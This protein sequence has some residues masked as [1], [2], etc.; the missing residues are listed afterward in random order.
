MQ[1][2]KNFGCDSEYIS[3]QAELFC[4]AGLEKCDLL[5]HTL[6]MQTQARTD[7]LCRAHYLASMG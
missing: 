3:A 6:R 5:V 4:T 2:E 1:N 7:L